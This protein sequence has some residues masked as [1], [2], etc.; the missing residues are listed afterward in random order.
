MVS[1]SSLE[2]LHRTAMSW[3]DQ[4]CSLPILRPSECGMLGSFVLVLEGGRLLTEAAFRNEYPDFTSQGQ[5][6]SASDVG[7]LLCRDPEPKKLL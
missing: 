1:T 4:H 5:T 2:E 7:R 6:G 3:L